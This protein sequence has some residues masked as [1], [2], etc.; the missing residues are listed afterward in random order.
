MSD[1]GATIGIARVGS[2]SRETAHQEKSE[3]LW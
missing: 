3:Q 2:P 1:E